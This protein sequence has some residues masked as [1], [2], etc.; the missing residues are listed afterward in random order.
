MATEKLFRSKVVGL[1]AM[2]NSYKVPE[3]ET[4]NCQSQ[5]KACAR[6][7]NTVVL[8]ERGS[9]QPQ[10]AAAEAPQ[11]SHRLFAQTW[12]KTFPLNSVNQTHFFCATQ[13]LAKSA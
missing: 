1:C 6:R 11:G 13:R 12:V 5:R 8:A 10:A 9:L 7:R 4:Q 2:P 3:K